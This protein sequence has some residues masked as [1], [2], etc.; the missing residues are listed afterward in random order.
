M[1]FGTMVAVSLL[2]FTVI[3]VQTVWTE[4]VVKD[5]DKHL[6]EQVY[7]DAVV[8]KNANLVFYRHGCPY[9][10]K[11]K[12]TVIVVAEKS[13]YPTFYI[14]VESADGQV[15]VKKYQ[16]EKA[17]SLVTIRDGQSQLYH[18]AAK[19]KNGQITADEKTIKEVLDDTKKTS[20]VSGRRR[21]FNLTM[22]CGVRK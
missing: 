14:D 18:Y 21:L 12:N 9:C 17:A 13:P 2:F 11:G 3:G 1:I 8:N 10:E 6:T 7:V 20:S 22:N 4:Y 15:L 5:Y 19:D 16:V